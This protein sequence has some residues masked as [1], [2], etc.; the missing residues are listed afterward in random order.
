MQEPRKSMEEWGNGKR[1]Q[2]MKIGQIMNYGEGKLYLWVK[3]NC[4][5]T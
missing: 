3:Y 4:K 2:E 5:Y 1:T